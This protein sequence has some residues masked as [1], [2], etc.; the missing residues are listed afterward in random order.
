MQSLLIEFFA[1]F[2]IFFLFAGLLVLW[3]ID[4]RIRKEQVAHALFACAIAWVIAFLIKTFFPTVRPF[5]VDG[6]GILTLT[7]PH[8]GSFPSEHAAIAFALSVT[9]F[10]HNKKAGWLFLI[11]AIVIG[12]ARVLANV[13]YPVDVFGGA[14]TGTLVAVVVEKSHVGAIINLWQKRK[15]YRR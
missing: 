2:W 3:V 6:G 7:V 11:S 8:D 1:S 10:M 13:H 4:G 9:I 14:L 5:W 15:A 12:V